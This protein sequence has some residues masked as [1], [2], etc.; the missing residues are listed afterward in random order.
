MIMPVT[1]D[2]A[3][4]RELLDALEAV[5]V[6]F[7]SSLTSSGTSPLLGVQTLKA[8]VEKETISSAWVTVAQNVLTIPQIARPIEMEVLKD[9]SPASRAA[10]R[11]VL[12]AFGDRAAFWCPMTSVAFDAAPEEWVARNFVEK[13]A[14]EYVRRLS[15]VTEPSAE[16]AADIA[17]KGLSFLAGDTWDVSHE[18]RVHGLWTEGE[19]HAVGE[20]VLAPLD[21]V[22]VG[23]EVLSRAPTGELLPISWVPVP[24]HALSVTS[25]TSRNAQADAGTTLQR[26][27]LG[28]QLLGFDPSGRSTAFLRVEPSWLYIGVTGTP[29]LISSSSLPSADF[30][31]L[32]LDE[33][34]RV[35]LLIP[36]AAVSEPNEPRST[37]LHRFA[38]GVVRERRYDGVLD[39]AIALEAALLAGLREELGYQFA[40]YGSHF[41]SDEPSLRAKAFRDLRDLYK[42]RS[43]LVHGS[44]KP[45]TREALASVWSVARD[46]ASAVLLKALRNGWPDRDSLT[47]SALGARS[48]S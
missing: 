13:T 5:R 9:V 42:M 2:G 23:R 29:V 40:L 7:L 28:V 39:L 15:S 32:D 31:S 34:V 22:V 16:V 27:L 4:T 18:L 6:A 3:P 10:A 24:T 36:D 46:H 21:D 19:T 44:K 33:A 26:L 45:P 1:V 43:D 17:A 35:A 12:D 47:Q 41:L 25:R 30:S 38:L 20:V 11:A 8:T 37:A 14:L 48:K